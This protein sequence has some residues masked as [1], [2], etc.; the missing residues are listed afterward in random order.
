MRIALYA[1]VVAVAIANVWISMDWL[2]KS[3]PITQGPRVVSVDGTTPTPQPQSAA[4]PNQSLTPV[5]PT[6]VESTVSTDPQVRAATPADNQPKP[7]D[8][9]VVTPATP[10][11]PANSPEAAAATDTTDAQAAAPQQEGAPR[12]DVQA[13]EAAYR[14]FR[15]SD[16]TYQPLYGDRRLC[17]KGGRVSAPANDN[18][19]GEGHEAS[20]AAQCNVAACS[21]AYRSFTASDCTY[22]PVD[23]PRRLCER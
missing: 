18:G 14:S 11:I 2:V 16:C 4:R 9:K 10:T 1:A 13:C 12:C 5:Y 8:A 17:T 21:Q 23:G 3:G 22:Q 20:A 15:A 7:S 6:K 19:E